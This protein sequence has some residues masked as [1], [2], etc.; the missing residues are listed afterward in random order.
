[1]DDTI[2]RK[3]RLSTGNPKLD[4]L[5]GG[6]LLPGTL[7][8]VS[9]A[10][11]IGKTQLGIQFAHAGNHQERAGGLVFDMSCRGDAQSHADYGRRMCGWRLSPADPNAAPDISQVFDLNHKLGDY[12]HVFDYA[13]RRVTRGD[14]DSDGWQDWQAEL[15]RKLTVTIA[16]FYG[17]FI[18][19]AR[20]VVVDGIE[21]ANRP[22]DSIQFEL[23]E[24]VYHQVLR[25]ESDWV[26]RDWL[27]EHF[28]ANSAAVEQNP[29]DRREVTCLLLYTAPEAMLE[30]LISRKLD[31]G[32]VLSNANTL[33]FLG[34]VREGNKLGRAFY[35]AK[36]RGSACS[37]EITPYRIGERGIELIC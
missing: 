37:D 23:F 27:R 36:H 30:E 15:A 4:E 25:K 6:G 12:L 10:T 3:S 20:R 5:L 33:I 16:F 22:S 26:A 29:Y 2:G 9:G 19:G 11:G 8:V 14:L 31:E 1:M 35:I 17:N 7:T 28:R 13:G 21:P 24:Y 32:D 18:R 34:K